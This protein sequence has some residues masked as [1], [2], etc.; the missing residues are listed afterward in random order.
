M[1]REHARYRGAVGPV[2]MASD[3]VTTLLIW[4]SESDAPDHAGLTVLW[5]A[6]AGERQRTVSLPQLV[7]LNADLLR[8]R[9]LAWIFDL[10]QSRVAGSSVI[11]HLSVRPGFSF[12]WMT[13]LAEKSYGKSSRLFDAVRMMALEDLARETG[14]DKISLATED[15]VL[16]EV[17]TLWCRRSGIDLEYRAP[18]AGV[19]GVSRLNPTKVVWLPLRAI[20]SFTRYLIERWRF[21]RSLRDTAGVAS[22]TIVD[23]LFHLPP[24]ALSD[25]GPV[26]GYWT[27]LVGVL[28]ASSKRVNWRHQ[29][30]PH[31]AVPDAAAAQ[32][33]IDQFNC[34]EADCGQVHAAWDADLCLR[35]IA[36]TIVDYVGVVWRAVRLREIRSQFTPASSMLD[37]WPLFAH[38]WRNSLYG[39]PALINCL[40]LNLF[41]RMLRRA[42]RQDLGLFL[43]ENQ[44]WEMAFVY[45][46]K[47]AGH[48]RLIGVPHSTIRFWD[49]R[50]F[51]DPRCYG[52]NG[53]PLPDTVAVNG[54]VAY[55]AYREAGFPME[56]VTEVEALRYQYLES[57]P[58]V[59]DAAVRDMTGGQTVLIL[60]DFLPA[61]TALQMRWLADAAPQLPGA[62]YIFKPHPNCPVNPEA[63]PSLALIVS[64]AALSE[65]LQSCDVVYTGN[66]TSAIVDAYCLGIPV[67]AMLDGTIFNLNPLRGLD[68]V[69][70]VRSPAELATALARRTPQRRE[71]RRPFFHL[72][73]TLPRWRHLLGLSANGEQAAA[74][75]ARAC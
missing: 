32:K 3:V 11:E 66:I 21:R 47:A 54:P 27:D 63:Y 75:R 60:G 6:F 61:I 50:Y 68:D 35:V 31:E 34:H 74:C 56:R 29:F 24:Q 44:A 39:S 15:P 70:Q 72:D 7:E 52:R 14:A 8:K 22:I 46:W 42:P 37:F 2:E 59:D 67:V 4:D 57:I 73:R 64:D 48:G 69:V 49:L 10:G 5:R 33:I 16:T 45:A 1:R 62:Q 58:V 53:M 13:L 28:R 20:M 23:Y 51:S 19:R 26:S 40:Y 41:E 36:R 18:L 25:G 12:W 65:L 55:E 71:V 43:L 9:Y 17:I 38:D 30:I